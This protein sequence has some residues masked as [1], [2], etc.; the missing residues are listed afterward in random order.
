MP[1]DV[2]D[3]GDTVVRKTT[4]PLPWWSCQPRFQVM[5][6][7]LVGMNW[8]SQRIWDWDEVGKGSEEGVSQ[9]QAIWLDGRACLLA[10]V[11]R[12]LEAVCC[13]DLCEELTRS[14]SGREPSPGRAGFPQRQPERTS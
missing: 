9:S 5:M 14:T 2:L 8:R 3:A 7:E 4:W 13:S 11:S 12:H 10:K 1:V 6:H